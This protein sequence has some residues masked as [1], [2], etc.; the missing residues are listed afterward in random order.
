MDRHARAKTRAS[1]YLLKKKMDCRARP[2]NDGGP[3]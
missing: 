2:G 1:I 3:A